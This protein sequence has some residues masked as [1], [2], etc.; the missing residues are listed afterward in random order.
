M[1]NQISDMLFDQDLQIQLL[2]RMNPSLD[3]AKLL[4]LYASGALGGGNVLIN[5]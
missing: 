5:Q 1:G 3:R 2:Q 4:Q